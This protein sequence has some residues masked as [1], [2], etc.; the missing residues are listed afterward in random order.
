MAKLT[1][2]TGAYV[3]ARCRRAGVHAGTLKSIDA[4]TKVGVLTDARRLWEWLS[5][6]G[7][8]L[9]GCAKHGIDSDGSRIDSQVD[10]VWLADVAEMIPCTAAAQATIVNAPDKTPGQITD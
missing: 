10:E 8:A 3:I 7:I 4:D 2:K 9:S 1:V 6:G 5:L